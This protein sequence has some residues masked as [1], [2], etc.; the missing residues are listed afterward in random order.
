MTF[1][2]NSSHGNYSRLTWIDSGRINPPAGRGCYSIPSGA[3]KWSSEWPRQYEVKLWPSLAWA[4]RPRCE[5]FN[6][7]DAMA[8]V[9]IGMGRRRNIERKL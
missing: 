4:A 1:D 6:T 8:E 7:H 2:R 5:K 9:L 3:G